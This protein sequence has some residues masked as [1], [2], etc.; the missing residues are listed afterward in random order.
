[1][2]AMKQPYKTDIAVLMLFFNRPETFRQAFEAV[3]AAR[4]SRLFLYQD[5]AREGN[6]A[7]RAGIEACRQIA[8]DENIDWQCDVQRHYCERNQG[9]DPSGYLSQRWAFSMADKVAV[10]EDDVVVAPTFLPFCKEMLDRYE[11]DDRITMVAG[12]NTDEMTPGVPYDYFF[13][14][15]F[16]IWGWASWRRVVD[17]WDGD[18]SF[19]RDSFNRQ[20]LAAIAKTRHL[21]HDFMQMLSDHAAA[22]KPFFESVFWAAMVM[23]NGLAVMPT[24]N[25]VSN[26]GATACSTHY[27][28]LM[29]M[30]RGLRRIFTMARHDVQ[31]PLRHP[32]YIMEYTPYKEHQYR[33][34]AWGHPWIKAM[35]SMEELW[36]NVR[37]GNVRRIAEAVKG[38]IGKWTG[39]HKHV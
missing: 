3:K 26:V 30:P 8:S 5:G 35:R 12:F 15:A 37:R 4:P 20:Q 23:G 36:L 32:R 22:G 16:S 11:H 38:R 27:T 31:F 33:A 39:R 18:Y 17:K 28:A 25:M 2:K 19:M 21:R 29:T 14:S 9:C 6:E 34:Y 13:T 1:M 24:R 10:V 7:D